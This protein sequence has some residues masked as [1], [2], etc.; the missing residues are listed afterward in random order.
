MRKEIELMRKEYPKDPDFVMRLQNLIEDNTRLRLLL[1]NEVVIDEEK[2]S[3]LILH[4][5]IIFFEH[6][7]KIRNNLLDEKRSFSQQLHAKNK[8]I[9]ELRAQLQSRPSSSGEQ[10]HRIISRFKHYIEE[11]IVIN[12][13]SKPRNR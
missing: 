13:D 5:F 3:S 9:E 8:E 10:M 2:K 4:Q 6:V 11:S 12:N 7:S 1:K